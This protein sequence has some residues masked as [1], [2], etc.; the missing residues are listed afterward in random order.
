MADLE[1]IHAPVINIKVKGNVLPYVTSEIRSLIKTKDSIQPAFCQVR[2]KVFSLL[3]KSI[4]DY[5]T[6][7]IEENKGDMVNG[8]IKLIPFG[9][10]DHDVIYMVKR[11]MVTMPK[12]KAK[13]KTLHVRNYKR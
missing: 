3:K 10:S 1:R 6:R 13:P 9:M 4:Q 11:Q 12:L 5:Y 8:M 7:R 2:S